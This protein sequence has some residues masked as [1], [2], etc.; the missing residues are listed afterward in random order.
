MPAAEHSHK[1]L[2]ARWWPTLCF[3]W[4]WQSGGALGVRYFYR[5]WSLLKVHVTAFLVSCTLF[6]FSVMASTP[7]MIFQ[8]GWYGSGE[9]ELLR[10]DGYFDLLQV[11][12]GLDRSGIGRPFPCILGSS[13]FR[14]FALLVSLVSTK[15]VWLWQVTYACLSTTLLLTVLVSILATRFADIN[16]DAIEEYMFRRAVV[17]F[18]GFLRTRE[19]LSP[20]LNALFDPGI[21]SDAIFN[22]WPPINLLALVA[23][24]PIRFVLTPRRFHSLNVFCTRT[25]NCCKPSAL[26]LKLAP[27]QDFLLHLS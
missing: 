26:S 6:G 22:Y 11:W 15:F 21:K 27:H 24:V 13:A 20:P 2:Y 4:C 14:V 23:L 7:S 18:E 16:R 5:R 25:S 19:I 9:S 12:S 3:W 1:E 17:V 8:N 10:V